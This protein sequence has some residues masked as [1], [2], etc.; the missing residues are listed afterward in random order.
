MYAKGLELYWNER[1]FDLG[2][3]T[4]KCELCEQQRIRYHFEIQ[5]I[6]GT[7]I[8]RVGSECVKKFAIQSIGRDGM[9]ISAKLTHKNVVREKS[10]LITDAR[11]NQVIKMLVVLSALDEDFDIERLLFSYRKYRAFTPKQLHLVIWR[12]N[13]HKFRLEQQGLHF[14]LKL[15]KMTIRKPDYQDQLRKMDEWKVKL[16]WVCMTASQRN[17]YTRHCSKRQLGN[18]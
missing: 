5:N 18:Q 3:C 15:L 14:P 2:D 17:W 6:D 10:R 11:F 1:V 4:G 13:T 9:I 8:L 7:Q 16:I 12:H